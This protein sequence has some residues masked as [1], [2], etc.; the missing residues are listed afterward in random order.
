MEEAKERIRN[1]RSGMLD[2]SY[3]GLTE[4]PEIPAGVTELDC[5]INQLT[6]LPDTLPSGLIEL[7]CD[8]NQLTTL[9]DTLPTGLR[10]LICNFNQL[11]SLP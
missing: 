11:L 5:K 10:M 7:S 6:S 3:L 1:W 4:L 2:L 9:P 8:Y